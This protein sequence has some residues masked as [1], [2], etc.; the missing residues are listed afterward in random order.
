VSTINT[1]LPLAVNGHLQHQKS[2]T[3][4]SRPP[5]SSLYLPTECGVP[6]L[7]FLC[8]KAL[9][10]YSWLALNPF[11]YYS[12]VSS[13][14]STTAEVFLWTFGHVD[15][16]LLKPYMKTV[17]SSQNTRVQVSN[18]D[19]GQD[20]VS[21]NVQAAAVVFL[22]YHHE[23]RTIIKYNVR[24][25]S[26]AE[27][28]YQ[29]FFLSL[30]SCRLPTGI[31]N[32]KRFLYRAITNDVLTMVRRSK[33]RREHLQTYIQYRRN[34]TAENDPGDRIMDNEDRDKVLGVIEKHLHPSEYRAIQGRMRYGRDNEK[35]ARK[36]GI[37]KRSYIRYLSVGLKKIR[38][39]NLKHEEVWG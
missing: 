32:M 5:V 29:E 26:V 4:D 6:I 18:D 34:G 14:F 15:G 36:L 19:P 22:K 35:A 1:G 24:D 31:G 11:S 20:G 16:G 23:I 8:D 2:S 3:C 39:L 7:N 17:M 28:V 25:E 21:E 33:R 12:R 13:E 38:K 9:V 30:V 37:K 27:D 10:Q